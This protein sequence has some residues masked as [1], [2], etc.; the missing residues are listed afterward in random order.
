MCHHACRCMPYFQIIGVSKCGTTDLY[1]R[2]KRHPDLADGAKV[3][4]EG[5]EA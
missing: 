3:R 1:N 5:R 2:L 4:K